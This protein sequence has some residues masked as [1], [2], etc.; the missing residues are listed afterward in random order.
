MM[1]FGGFI[2]PKIEVEFCLVA[3]SIPPFGDAVEQDSQQPAALGIP[4]SKALPG[5]HGRC[6]R[7]RIDKVLKLP[8]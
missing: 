7:L 4:K 8:E 5:R 1:A 3:I 2:S 6:L